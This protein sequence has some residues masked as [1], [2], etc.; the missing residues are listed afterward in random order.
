MEREFLRGVQTDLRSTM[1][2][3]LPA[4]LAALLDPGEAVS[5]TL[6]RLFEELF[7]RPFFATA[8]GERIYMHQLPIA[9]ADDPD[10]HP[11]E[12]N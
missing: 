7:Y 12:D 6:G 2:R 9:P 3:D 5:G 10:F 1:Y 4:G 11:R 8:A